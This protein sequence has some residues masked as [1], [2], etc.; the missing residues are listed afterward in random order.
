MHCFI[1]NS[2]WRLRVFSQK[3]KQAFNYMP[4]KSSYRSYPGY[5]FNLYK[6]KRQASKVSEVEKYSI[7]LMW[8]NETLKPEQEYIYPS[9]DIAEL[10]EQFLAPALKWALA[11]PCAEVNIW[12]DSVQTTEEA[13]T[14]TQDALSSVCDGE[15]RKKTIH[16]RDIREIPIVHDNPDAFSDYLPI[17]FRIDI[18]KAIIIVDEIERGGKDA[19]IFSDLEVGNL[20]PNRDRMNKEELF[21]ADDLERFKRLGLTINMGMN[22]EN[23]FLQLMN[24]PMMIYAIKHALINVNLTRAV[25]ALNF[26][27]E[28]GEDWLK[29]DLILSLSRAVFRSLDD[30]F[31]FYKHITLSGGSQLVV[32]PDIVGKGSEKDP[33]IPYVLDEHGYAPF[34]LYCCSIGN[35]VYRGV[36]PNKIWNLRMF[37]FDPQ[38]SAEDIFSVRT[39]DVR[40][41]KAHA[42]FFEKLRYR[43]PVSKDGIYRCKLWNM[44]EGIKSIIPF[45]LS[46]K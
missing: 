13:I 46:S 30:I 7:N 3:Y 34:G 21:A 43:P 28:S 15:S 11:N 18:L 2:Y 45:K 40:D 44:D 39:V 4:A 31:Y 33:K 22:L 29:K 8:I 9:K 32:R 1:E 16:L 38:F 25:V 35:L 14:R 12:Y 42:P 20:R 10:K 6:Q 19:A 26:K 17:Y 36:H 27:P 37:E 5:S 23:Q 41:G 24:N